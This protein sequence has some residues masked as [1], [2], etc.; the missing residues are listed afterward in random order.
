MDLAERIVERENKFLA[1][2]LELTEAGKPIYIYGAGFGGRQVC[3]RL[4]TRHV[5]IEGMVED[6]G[7]REHECDA[8][9]LEDVLD[10]AKDKVC[11][12]VAFRGF[13]ADKLAPYRGKIDR[14]ID[15]D[16]WAGNYAVDS[17]YVTYEWVEEHMDRLQGVYE[18]LCDEKSKETFAAYLNQKISMDFKYL[19]KTKS[20]NQYFEDD[21]VK[22][23][24]HE[25]F[26]DC[27][28]YDGDS[29]AA[30]IAALG[31]NGRTSYDEIISFEPDFENYK[32]LC[33]RNFRNHRCICKGVSDTPGSVT[34]SMNGT[35]GMILDAENAG[36][37]VIELDTLDH[38]LGGGGD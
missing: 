11:L 19:K 16:C 9:C 23:S 29:A 3:S 24:D 25:V 36:N 12:I 33:Q 35:L 14:V 28:A 20:R 8:S 13:S 32:K 4:Q 38:V 31:R 34:F 37:A 5:L 6:A 10:Q 26:A 1:E 2:V 22:L 30:F 27:G 15:R 7:C 21:I 17:S 18:K